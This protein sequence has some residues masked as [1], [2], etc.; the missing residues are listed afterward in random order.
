MSGSSSHVPDRPL[1]G[2]WK[3]LEWP[4]VTNV[5]CGGLQISLL[6]RTELSIMELNG[7]NVKGRIESV[8]ITRTVFAHEGLSLRSVSSVKCDS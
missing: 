3:S 4:S 6:D 1:S 8:S 5:V 7:H 2:S